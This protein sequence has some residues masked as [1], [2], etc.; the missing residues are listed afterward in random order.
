MTALEF[1]HQ[2]ISLEDKLSRFALSLTANRDDAK[3]LL[4]E[5]LYK[6]IVYRDQF[7]QYTN[8]KAWTYTIMKNTFINDYR[9]SVRHHSFNINDNEPFSI[10]QLI[11]DG[12]FEA[13]SV[14]SAKEMTICIEELSDMFRIPFKMYLSGYKYKE[15][16]EELEL[17]IGTI[18]SRIFLS[19]KKLQDQ[20]SR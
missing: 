1:N 9:R 11:S 3:D 20:L 14:Y 10:N 16:A 6:A 13:D 19:R 18:K 12:T 17:N 2:L 7:V 4:Q 8:L 15:I 5:T